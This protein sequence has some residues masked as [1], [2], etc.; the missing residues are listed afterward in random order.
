MKKT[1]REGRTRG[2]EFILQQSRFKLNLRKNFLIVRTVGDWNKLP[3]EAEEF[4]S[5]EVIESEKIRLG[6]DLRRSHLVQLTAQ[7]RTIPS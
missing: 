2:G 1:A 4:P 3:R 6:T 5:L 7:R